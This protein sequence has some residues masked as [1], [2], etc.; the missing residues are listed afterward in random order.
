MIYVYKIARCEMGIKEV[1]GDN[2]NPRILEYLK[3]CESSLDMH[4]EIPWCSAFVNW[5]IERYGYVGTQSLSARSWMGWGT[6]VTEP[7]KGAVCILRRGSEPWMGHVG[8]VAEWDADR[9]FILGGNQS[10]EVR[11]SEYS[12]DR[13]LGYRLL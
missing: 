8:F 10:N 13:V 5:V 12:K 7:V 2:D 11:I 9:V 3:T 4:D 6:S 1:I